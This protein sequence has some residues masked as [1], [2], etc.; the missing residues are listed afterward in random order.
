MKM[1]NRVVTN[2][3]ALVIITICILL[4]ALT[5]QP[6]HASMPILSLRKSQTK[7]NIKD[8]CNCETNKELLTWEFTLKVVDQKLLSTYVLYLQDANSSK[9]LGD[10]LETVCEI[11]NTTKNGAYHVDLESNY[12][13]FN[14]GGYIE[15]VTP[16]RQSVNNVLQSEGIN[17]LAKYSVSDTTYM[18]VYFDSHANGLSVDTVSPL[19]HVSPEGTKIKQPNYK[20][21]LR[22]L[23]P[24]VLPYLYGIKPKTSFAPQPTG[25]PID[26]V[27]GMD[28]LHA[29]RTDDAVINYTGYDY[30]SEEIKSVKSTHT[31]HSALWSTDS[32]VIRIGYNESNPDGSQHLRG[33][34]QKVIV[35]PCNQITD[36]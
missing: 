34:I 24:D 1:I 4:M 8:K 7:E 15:C 26:F 22:L 28:R 5:V 35:D 30:D 33:N 2:L 11:V 17:P 29:Q 27:R 36:W 10:P 21:G 32:Q 9:V 20:M 12:A 14:G 23:S 6:S 16:S 3:L 19:V 13:S 25:F 31:Y 18:D